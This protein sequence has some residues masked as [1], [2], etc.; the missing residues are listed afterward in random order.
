MAAERR[1]PAGPG[2]AEAGLTFQE[3]DIT[4]EVGFAEPVREEAGW[5]G[6]CRRGWRQW[7]E[8]KGGRAAGEAER[9]PL[10]G[11]PLAPGAAGGRLCGPEGAVLHVSLNSAG[12]HVFKKTFH[13]HH[14]S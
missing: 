1:K 8:R 3:E 4:E 6:A 2:L 7:A 12:T 10:P 11:A 5:G 9:R 13:C 14:V